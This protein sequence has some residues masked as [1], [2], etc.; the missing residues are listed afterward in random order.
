MRCRLAEDVL[1]KQQ[2]K[3]TWA[4]SDADVP[5]RVGQNSRAIALQIALT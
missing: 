5:I 4:V 2:C 3:R 1:C